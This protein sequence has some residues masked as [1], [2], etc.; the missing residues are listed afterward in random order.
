M[1]KP[2]KIDFSSA[3]GW[4]NLLHSWA[5]N[6]QASH[7][8]VR[9]CVEILVFETSKRNRTFT[10]ISTSEWL[11]M[12]G[13]KRWV[14]DVDVDTDVVVVRLGVIVHAQTRF[15]ARHRMPRMRVAICIRMVVVVDVQE[16]S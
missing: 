8:S 9:N 1:I 10:H 14:S 13:L 5:F 2:S 15:R 6:I 12:S 11:D 16:G 3:S 7:F 4:I